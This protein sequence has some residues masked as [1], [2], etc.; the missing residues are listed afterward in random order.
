MARAAAAKAADALKVAEE[1][2]RSAEADATRAE[3]DA[4]HGLELRKL[5]AERKASE[6]EKAL[7][8]ATEAQKLVDASGKAQR[9]HDDHA[10]AVIRAQASASELAGKLKEAQGKLERCELLER[11]LALRVAEAQV[12]AK[13]VDVRSEAAL[14]ER[15]TALAGERDSLAARRAGITVPEASRL[16][17]MRKL[18]TELATAR[19]AL[20]VGLV[21][22]VTPAAP[23]LPVTI[24]LDGGAP[25]REVIAQSFEAE[26]NAEV[27]VTIADIATVRVR[28]GRRDAQQRASELESRWT[29]EVAPALAMAGVE[30]LDALD[31]KVREARDLDTQVGATNAQLREL[32]VRQEVLAGAE[33]A[34][35]AAVAL[36]TEARVGLEPDVLVS[37]NAELD[38]LAGEPGAALR[39]RRGRA[40]TD[41]EQAANVSSK[42]ATTQALADQKAVALRG[43]LDAAVAARDAAVARFP[44]GV[45]PAAEAARGAQQAASAELKE[46]TGELTSLQS[47]T[48]ARAR[49]LAD[50][51]RSASELAASTRQSVVAADARVTSAL[52]AH[53]SEEGRLLEL[54]RQLSA[55][56]L[57]ATETA[58]QAASERLAALPVPERALAPGEVESTRQGV[59]G[60][61]R[62]LDEIE[63]EV[64]R[65]QGALEQVGGAVARE[66]LRDAVEAFEQA[67]RQ[68]RELEAEY[69]AWK[70]LLEQMK[71]ADAAQASNLGQALAPAIANQFQTLTALRYQGLQLTPQLGTDGI[72][73]GGAVRP[74]GRLSVGTREQLSTLYRICLGEYLQTAIVLDDQL[75]QSDGTRMDWF[76]ALL[77]AKAR[78]FQIVVFTCRPEDYLPASAMPSGEPAHADSEGGVIRAVDLRRAVRPR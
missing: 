38:R 31:A 61:R 68:E 19:G 48:D 53:A 12:A 30:D 24:A 33:Q 27:D 45:T 64:H 17:P 56:D 46:V 23:P 35:R 28:G 59:A 15:L 1:S 65:T 75:V 10:Q 2:A 22:T 11:A 34:L 8:E 18:A 14:Q 29:R 20:T 6:A 77:G 42:A 21:V 74:S 52:T 70:L 57:A 67:E 69:E 43:A 39:L 54:R 78:S 13:D 32:E 62:E 37:L 3:T 41:V 60:L 26:V 49:H 5:G 7:S 51:L 4:R 76:R 16:V 71:E 63:R 36:A 73:V 58:A 47:T 55:E 72:V 44:S 25:S 40:S 50:S 66:G 9:E